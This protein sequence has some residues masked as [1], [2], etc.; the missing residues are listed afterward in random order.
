M[1]EFMSQREITAKI[2]TT[3]GIGAITHYRVAIVGKQADGLLVIAIEPAIT[4]TDMCGVI[5]RA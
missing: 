4:T 2:A 5:K 3:A 1:T